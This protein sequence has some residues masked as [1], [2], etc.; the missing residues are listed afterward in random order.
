MP[1]AEQLV[2]WLDDNDPNTSFP[3]KDLGADEIL[4]F[5]NAPPPEN[6]PSV[7]LYGTPVGAARLAGNAVT[8]AGVYLTGNK[9]LEWGEKLGIMMGTTTKGASDKLRGHVMDTLQGWGQVIAE[10]PPKAWRDQV[11]QAVSNLAAPGL[12]EGAFTKSNVYGW[13]ATIETQIPQWVAAKVGQMAGGGLGH[14]VAGPVGSKVGEH[15]GGMAPLVL[16]EAGSWYTEAIERGIEP[17]LARKYARAYGAAS[18]S[19][20]YLQT[21]L[22]M[23]GGKTKG[24]QGAWKRLMGAI[25]GIAWEGGEEGA[26]QVVSN[27]AIQMAASEQFERGGE[28]IKAPQLWDNVPESVKVAMMTL[29]PATGFTAITGGVKDARRVKAA[30]EFLDNFKNVPEDSLLRQEAEPEVGLEVVEPKVEESKE[31]SK[32]SEEGVDLA[33]KIVEDLSDDSVMEVEEEAEEGEVEEVKEDV[34]EE[35]V[36]I[37]EKEEEVKEEDLPTFLLKEGEGEGGKVESKTSKKEAKDFLYR[38]DER[39]QGGG[40]VS[41]AERQADIKIERLRNLYGYKKGPMGRRREISRE[42]WHKSYGRMAKVA[43]IVW[44]EATGSPEWSWFD[45]II[46]APEG[47]KYLFNSDR[48][49]K[50][51]VVKKLVKDPTTIIRGEVVSGDQADRITAIL[52]TK[53]G[54]NPKWND[55]VQ[56]LTGR[57]L[58]HFLRNELGSGSEADA[59]IS[60]AGI[61]QYI[62]LSKEGDLVYSADFG[63]GELTPEML[64]AGRVPSL[65]EMERLWDYV[66]RDVSKSTERPVEAFLPEGETE[67]DI[68]HKLSGI[69]DPMT[70]ATHML[71]ALDRARVYQKK[72]FDSR[73]VSGL[74]HMLDDGKIVM[75]AFA[76]PNVATGLHELAHVWQANLVGEQRAKAEKLFGSKKTEG[77]FWEKGPAEDFANAFER[78]VFEG[79][80]PSEELR[81]PFLMLKKWLKGIYKRVE[82]SSIDVK[83]SPGME[84]FFQNLF[85]PAQEKSMAVTRISSLRTLFKEEESGLPF[86]SRSLF[87]RA[88]DAM[89]RAVDISGPLTRIPA[90]KELLVALSDAESFARS[91]GGPLRARNYE[92]W[93]DISHADK[94]KLVKERRA[95]G[96]TNFRWLVEEATLYEMGKWSEEVQRFVR[97]ARDVQVVLGT[98]AKKVGILQKVRGKWKPALYHAE[99]RRLIRALT[100]DAIRLLEQTNSPEYVELLKEL[101]RQNPKQ[102]FGTLERSIKRLHEGPMRARLGLLEFARIIESFPDFFHLKNG[103]TIQLMTIDP[104]GLVEREITAQATRIGQVK[105]LGQGAIGNVGVTKIRRAASLLG[106][107]PKNNKQAQ[108]DRMLEAGVPASEL[109]G[110]SIKQ[111]R[112]LSK[113]LG[114]PRGFTRAEVLNAIEEFTDVDKLSEKQMEGL[115]DLA[116]KV[117]G[118]DWDQPDKGLF[119]ARLK[120]RLMEDV[121]DLFH[122]YEVRYKRQGGDIKDFRRVVEA[123]QGVNRYELTRH[124]VMRVLNAMMGVIGTMHTSLA[125][126]PNIVQPVTLIPVYTGEG[127][128]LKALANVGKDW[129]GVQ[130][131]GYNLGAYHPLTAPKGYEG[132]WKIEDASRWIRKKVGKAFLLTQNLH[133]NNVIAGEA[134]RLLAN[135]WSKEGFKV[136]E[137]WVAKELHLS[138]K[139]IEEIRSKQMSPLTFAKVIQN[140]VGKTQYVTEAIYRQGMLTTNPL[141]RRM[142]SYQ[143]YSTGAL[144][145]SIGLVKSTKDAFKVWRETGNALPAIKMSGKVLQTMVHY[146]GTGIV[147]GA[148]RDL[149]YNRD[150]WPED[151]TIWD[152]ALAG[153]VETQLLGPTT[154]MLFHSGGYS[155]SS[156]QKF[157]ISFMPQV[158]AMLDVVAM[159]YNIGSQALTGEGRFGRNRNLDPSTQL[160]KLGKRHFGAM[161][162]LVGQVELLAFP[163]RKDYIDT[164]RA[165]YEWQEK[166]EGK[167]TEGSWD[168]AINPDYYYIGEHLKNGSVPEARKAIRE[169]LRKNRKDMDRATRRLKSALNQRRPIPVS[170]ERFLRFLASQNRE[171]RIRF[172][173]RNR[174]YNT[175]LDAVIP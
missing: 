82:G 39:V 73:K 156:I 107:L 87:D 77:G 29:G 55:V 173:R 175:T 130:R 49:T 153:L 132:G 160:Y 61:K 89:W 18:G 86:V 139:E 126:I 161:R 114:I 149:V 106:V 37:E 68:Y 88:I 25:T 105:H 67:F 48:Y 111:L 93:K 123:A 167:K 131:T 137:E 27:L 158:K 84:R 5:L 66:E 148:M 72:D 13:V 97:L 125:A 16:M 155:E 95:E 163:R 57:E 71:L 103:K 118:V 51:D 154:R 58:Y 150:P 104:F 41:E 38:F 169:F 121:Q 96:I 145:A 60:E 40:K 74:A 98:A 136:G 117:Q 168:A 59:V 53:E 35:E 30:Q 170:G 144:R 50:S 127:I 79:F 24:V 120:E 151:E 3:G 102:E 174:V 56:T 7:M 91:L 70:A 90:G 143:S 157:A 146:A 108:V 6:D 92:L 52:E 81:V 44:E 166:V 112:A 15:V 8:G 119:L 142:Y 4:D 34:K 124:P 83:L 133:K 11:D 19:V 152:K 140:G 141:L 165:F 75:S 99:G 17:D 147:V 116:K 63:E 14:L 69:M 47:G 65:E 162:V 20:E 62:D 78:W 85:L 46:V 122:E 1:T 2:S 80:P 129:K 138:E 134:F 43:A 76:A 12:D 9:F 115:R 26:Q 45:N 42:D 172:F 23:G 110:K 94:R 164:R 36:E 64:R 21:L 113:E 100:G 109:A 54:W 31:G 10:A 32:G 171:D 33:K 101:E 28:Q 159:T 128:F 22:M 135:K